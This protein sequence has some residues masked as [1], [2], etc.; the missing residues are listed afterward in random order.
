MTKL[1]TDYIGLQNAHQA[2][3]LNRSFSSTN[4]ISF[5]TWVAEGVINN[6][7]PWQNW[8]PR[9]LALRGSS[10]YVFDSP[11]MSSED[12][13]SKLSSEEEDTATSV[14]KFKM[15]EAMFRVIKESENV[16][17][18]QHCF[19]IQ[20][21]GKQSHYFSLET[22]Q[23]LLRLESAWHK[24]VCLA[25]SHL[26]SKTFHV[27][28]KNKPSAFTLDWEDGFSLK[29]FACVSPEWTYQFSQLKGSSD[30][31]NATL[32]LH[33]SR[34][35]QQDT[36]TEEVICPKLQELLFFM[37]SFLTAKVASLDP[38]FLPSKS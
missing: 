11:P 37:H 31:G 15:F 1:I 33:F 25:I 22:R 38:S 2:A 16:D 14:T 35:L 34:P 3:K 36:V 19:L 7:Q 28:Y 21:F 18:R 30:D 4:Q 8:R 12:W 27:V 10:V 24:S 17:E 6:D 20:A 29:C 32:K 26:G 5:M 13:D 9:F 23:E